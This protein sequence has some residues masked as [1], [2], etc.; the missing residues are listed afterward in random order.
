MRRRHAFT[1][2]LVVVA[3]VG[4]AFAALIIATQT[5]WGRERV[6]GRVEALIQGSSHGIVRIGRISGNLRE[7]FTL[8]DLVITDSAQ[9]PFVKAK[10]VW[11]RYT[12]STLW[13]RKLEFD[14]VK[15]VN[16]VI[17]LDR[18]P[19]GKWNYDRIFPRDTMTR[20][21]PR[22]TGWGT[23]IRFTDVTIVDGDL[24]VR[25]PWEPTDTL[26][27]SQR[28]KAIMDALNAK[29]RLLVER[30]PGGF[31]RVS[32]YYN[33]NSFIPLLRLEDPGFST[34]RVVITRAKLLAEPF[35]PPRVQVMD[36]AGT[37]DFDGDSVWWRGARAK[38]PNSDIAGDGIYRTDNGNMR[39]R[40][41]TDRVA[42]ADLRWIHPPLP[43]RGSG[44]MDFALD[45]EGDVQKYTAR[46]AE[47]TLEGG[48]VSGD[49]GVTR[50]DTIAIHDTNLRFAN[51]DTRLVERI[52][53][54]LKP[55]RHGI[56]S[57]RAKLDGGQNALAVDGDIT[58]TDRTSG[59]SRL[60]AVGTIGFGD[61]FDARNLRLRMMPLRMALLK[62]FMPDIPIGGTLSG[63]ATLNG[64]SRGRMTAKGDVTHL[65]R[66]GRSRLVG[67]ASF[68]TGGNPWF[69]IDATLRPLALATA[70][71]FAPA[72]GLRGTASGPL[73]ITGTLR[74]FAVDTR[75]AF[76]DG[77]SLDLRGRLDLA[78][79][80]KGY[81]LTADARLF[82]ANAIIAK[83]PPTS[84]TAFAKVTGRGT[85]PAT[86][87][88]N[89]FADVKAS[90]YDTLGV[91]SAV[92]R[93]AIANGLADID[94]ATILLREGILIA[95]GNFGLR[96]G[97][98]GELRYRVAI[99]SLGSF[100]RFLPPADSGVTRPRPGILARRVAGAL[101][102]SIRVAQKTEVERAVT[103]K[104][105]PRFPVD[106]PTV[107]PNTLLAGSVRAEGVATGNIRNFSVRG[108]ADGANIIAR[109]NTA[110]LI[111]ADYTWINARMPQSQLSV[112][113]TGADVVASGFEM[114]SLNAKL[115][116]QKPRGTAE[117]VIHQDT[118]RTYALNSDYI[119][120]KDNNELRLNTLRLKFDTTVWASTGASRLNWGKSGLNVTRLELRNAAAGRIYLN[121]ILPREGRADFEIA[122]DNFN[123]ADA[124]ALLESDIPASGFVSL[125]VKASGTAADPTFRGSFG[126]EKFVYNGTQ[127]PEL[128]G[129]VSYA[130]QTLT[131]R[132]EGF[133][134]GV[135]QHPSLFAIEGTIPI[136]LAF[137]GVTGSRFPRDR[138]IDLAVA[139]DSLPLDLIP[140]LGSIV[141]NVSGKTTA[142]FKVAGTLNKPSITGEFKLADGKARIVPVGI[143]LNEVNASI[144]LRRDTVVIDSIVGNSSGQIALYGGIGLPSFY[145]PV[146]DLR[147]RSRNA[148]VLDNDKGRL[149]ATAELAISGPIKDVLVSGG[150]TLREGVIRIP[151]SDG[152]KLLSSGDPALF[153][154]L[155]TAIAANRELF[156]TQHPLLANL[157]MD[158]NLRVNRDVFVRSREAN[159]EVYSDGDLIVRV[160]RK[161]QSL[162]LDGVLLTERGEYNF[163]TKRFQVKRGS[164]TFINQA[165]INPTLQGTAEY[166]VRLPAREAIRIRILV[167]GT[168]KTPTI[169]LESDAQPP[170]PQSDL[171]SYL[172]FGRT[173][174]SLLQLEG[175]GVTGGSGSDNLVGAGAALATKQLATVAVG[176]FADQIAGEAA[177]SL[178]ADVF[179]ITPADIQTDVGGFLRAT[180]I[181]FGKYIKSHTFVAAQV[182]PDPEALKRPGLFM[183]HRFGGKKGYRLETSLQPRYLL[184]VPTL[185]PQEPGTTSV[186]GVFLI[187]EWRY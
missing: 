53:P 21:G 24:H 182:R 33:I 126:T 178:G 62:Q 82:N 142:N 173:S 138:E 185:A 131:G 4:M 12:L 158:V 103:G 36:L 102:D 104:Q 58:F 1:G 94:T 89:I 20:R 30:V 75:L 51:L 69:D 22:K 39:L 156:P 18:Q 186:L 133:R 107:I 144:R 184:K 25:S 143:N 41:H 171:L 67:K 54:F 135:H 147:F 100:A 166:E 125:D 170:I 92:V 110:R 109:G 115:S 42:S 68:T 2:L 117:L 66:T 124:I 128:H 63:S 46:N 34:R 181:E 79:Q 96:A 6:R 80:A 49:L 116:Y 52:L 48:R 95:S 50:G 175:T 11:G 152:K 28:E 86:M 59:T 72:L 113:A 172:A 56:V 13:G 155:D 137:T 134:E 106:T 154:V 105:L 129:T 10:E 17:V 74:D 14:D 180:E 150:I 32:R 77:G 55:P 85:D 136:N 139:A 5:D 83:A 61:G 87:R 27:S 97:R 161:A 174:A 121:G 70:G 31:Q 153:N 64:T 165:E 146:F 149:R 90:S 163:L 141:S 114:D 122:V 101:S 40:L 78:S 88:A 26:S 23:W 15:L 160:N 157:R 111:R 167:G 16:P 120:N 187:R 162:A 60:A 29:S 8:H 71:R 44:R 7:G 93:V 43:E 81:D 169:A 37:F 73:R 176:V 183:Q 151:E 3:L 57:G 159:I 45:W 47:F 99:D 84:I 112:N 145:A 76:S 119:L 118:K 140:Q 91:E 123:V 98:S 38:L 132:A 130:N 127:L 177:Q 9:R 179:N 35:R 108:T 19:G 148:R 164:A 168:L 65:D